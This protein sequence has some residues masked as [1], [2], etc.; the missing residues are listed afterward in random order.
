MIEIFFARRP[1]LRAHCTVSQERYK[2]KH[3]LN[4][5]VPLT[6]ERLHVAAVSFHAEHFSPRRR[7][8]VFAP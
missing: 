8:T 6:R 4:W 7:F 5:L 1:D 2:P 3:A